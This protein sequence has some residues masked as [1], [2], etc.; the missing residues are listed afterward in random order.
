M[1]ERGID[2]RWS[3][4]VERVGDACWTELWTEILPFWVK[5]SHDELSGGWMTCLDEGG[6]KVDGDKLVWLQGR[7]LWMYSHLLWERERERE[8]EGGGSGGD[9]EGS[10]EEKEERRR[11]RMT[12]LKKEEE[13]RMR[14]A[15]EKA[16]GL[17]MRCGR[18]E[19]V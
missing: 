11:R 12:W 16:F 6:N 17:L 14:E 4:L 2:R 8:S 1:D 7:Q 10:E 9:G 15:A 13:K 5:F 18:D 3:D 19:N